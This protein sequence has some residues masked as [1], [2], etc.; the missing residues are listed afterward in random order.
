MEPYLIASSLIVVGAQRLCR[1]ICPNC[2][3]K[4]SVSESLLES[5]GY[6]GDK[7]EFFQGKGCRKCAQTGYYGRMGVLEVLEMD[8][9]IREMILNRSTT[10]EIQA[11]AQKKG[12]RTIHQDAIKKLETGVTT[13]EEVM[14]VT[15]QE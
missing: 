15:V 14:R 1:I 8:D 7:K 11:H 9:A 6:R 10:S 4:V 13:V 5:V 3:G 12:M 2:K